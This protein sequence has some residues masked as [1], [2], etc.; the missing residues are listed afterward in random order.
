MHKKAF[1]LIIGL[2]SFGIIQAQWSLEKCP[3]NSNL[4]AISF[5]KSN[6]GWIVGDK[7]TILFRSIAGWNIFQKPTNENLYSVFML[8]VN[9]GWAVGGRGT[10]LHFD[11]KS[12]N[13]IE[14]PTQ[15]N[16][17]SVSFKDNKNGIAVGENGVILIYKDGI[18]ES[19]N[20]KTRGNL[21]AS[22]FV[23]DEVWIGGGLECVDVPIIKVPYNNEKKFTN[24][25]NPLATIT[26]LVMLDPNNG[27]AVGSPSTILHFD[28]Q[29]WMKPLLNFSFPSLKSIFFSVDTNGIS[30]GY[31]GTI[32]IFSGNNWVME[33]SNIPKNL[34]GTTIFENNYYAVGDSGTII[35]KKLTTNTLTSK[36]TSPV[37][38]KVEVF[39]NPCNTLLNVA[40]PF[41]N[42]YSTGWISITDMGGRQFLQKKFSYMMENSTFQ[43]VTAD[44]KNG[45]YILKTTIEGTISSTIFIVEH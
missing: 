23:K 15:N 8:D 34:N 32:L 30:V 3:T 22:A 24:S 37:L 2:L 42:E 14:S 18:W 4:N 11:G 17:F 31:G 27:W 13:K 7:G 12:W 9:N 44:L 19:G 33:N 1:L 40:I 26:S 10:I 21:F 41:Q 5:V 45:L 20:R 36:T 39:P 38:N 25:F 16:L 29:Q 43:I 35:K 28:G 6:S